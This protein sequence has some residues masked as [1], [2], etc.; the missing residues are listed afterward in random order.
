MSDRAASTVPAQSGLA[1]D[2][3]AADALIPTCRS[4]YVGAGGNIKVDM[5]NGVAGLTFVGAVTGSTLPID[6]SK[7]YTSGTTASSL[8]ILS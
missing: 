7:V 8:I 3:S 5:R 1:I 6:V 4:I 2:V